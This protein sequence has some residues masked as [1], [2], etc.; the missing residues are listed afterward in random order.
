MSS[1][2]GI[3]ARFESASGLDE[4]NVLLFRPLHLLFLC[5]TT[6]T[7]ENPRTKLSTSAVM[8]MIIFVFIKEVVVGF[9]KPENLVDFSLFL[10]FL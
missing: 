2:D 10:D 6:L 3:G 1:F 9:S 8:P 5:A 7:T 4:S